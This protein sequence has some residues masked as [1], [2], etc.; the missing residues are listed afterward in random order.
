M[1]DKRNDSRLHIPGYTINVDS[2]ASD[3]ESIRR[4]FEDTDWKGE[5]DKQKNDVHLLLSHQDR[6]N[7]LAAI[8]SQFIVTA[9]Q[10]SDKPKFVAFPFLELLQSILLMSKIENRSTLLC[11]NE[12]DELLKGCS[13]LFDAFSSMQ[14]DKE[15]ITGDV[16]RMIAWKAKVHTLYYRFPFDLDICNCLVE[17]ISTKFDRKVSYKYQIANRYR[18]LRDLLRKHQDRLYEHVQ[19]SIA[20]Q[21]A[22]T[23]EQIV[24]AIKFFLS[25]S[26][27]ARREWS[28]Q[29]E[30][31]LGVDE[32]QEF[33]CWL[34]WASQEWIYTFV[35]ED[36]SE[37]DR[38]TLK[39]L[40]MEF[41]DL[42]NSDF[43]HF[44][45]DNPVWGK[46]FILKSDGNYFTGQPQAA[47][48]FPFQILEELIPDDEGARSNFSQCR[49]EV[50]E[51][52][53]F[54]T[55]SQALPSAMVYKG[56]IWKSPEN[57]KWYENDVVAILG[58]QIFMFEA[59]SGKI[60]N[61]ARRGGIQSLRKSLERLFVE[62]ARQSER[63]QGYLN[64]NQNKCKLYEKRSKEEI[65]LD[66]LKPKA[67]YRFS[68][69]I[70]GLAS[71]T[72]GRRHFE[73]LG[74]IGNDTP[75]APSLSI[76]E[77][78]MIFRFLDSEVSFS[79]YLSRRYSIE[80]V[81]RFQ[82]DE[83]DL[84]SMYLAN[85]FYIEG[86]NIND[87]PINFENADQL[88][89][90]EKI[91]KSDRRSAQVIGVKLPGFWECLVEQIYAG[92]PAYEHYK[93]DIL[94]TVL[95]Q[96]PPSLYRLQ[97]RIQKWRS[98]AGGKSKDG[99]YS[100]YI[101]GNRQYVLIVNLFEARKVTTQ[102]ELADTC[103][104]LAT[105]ICSK[106]TGTSDCLTLRF[107]KRT[108][109]VTYDGIYFFRGKNLV[110]PT[111]GPIV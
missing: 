33:A 85:G 102:H 66:L 69:T 79:H 77:L 88:V 97:K 47:L 67:V 14:V 51:E 16:A 28:R 57:G 32:L 78:R 76:S 34:A 93:F 41:G 81:L 64:E 54:E 22:T 83:Q 23:K 31:S 3:L 4:T 70:E 43:D 52:L 56:V 101:I 87:I 107:N 8:A 29:Y 84:L 2:S 21:E 94:F 24:S 86:S 75:W 46:P 42:E 19:H 68:V 91:P 25:K 17:R 90:R 98:G 96:P 26:E 39:M 106:F 111:A 71:I 60:S 104:L 62:P 58:N 45:L 55:V 49:S 89:R 48:T 59:K 103:R 100:K 27:S 73:E 95:N 10:C 50:L 44:F 6:Y 30:D 110:S 37:L 74:L 7:M 65:S 13:S 80:Q 5:F 35:N 18:S 36:L 109:R 82:G 61:V 12:V 15:G 20:I 9:I 63:L 99:E 53:V 11:P 108:S 38:Q 1:I 92:D 40:S 105:E 72:S